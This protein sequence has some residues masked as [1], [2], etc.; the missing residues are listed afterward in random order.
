[1]DM[2]YGTCT[3]KIEVAPDAKIIRDDICDLED[4]TVGYAVCKYVR[5]NAILCKGLVLESYNLRLCN[6]KKSRPQKHKI[7]VLA[8][9]M[10]LPGEK[11]KVYLTVNRK[12]VIVNQIRI[13]N[14]KLL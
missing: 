10:S 1:M 9:K 2:K 12:G 14:S 13:E 11:I 8:H 3:C 6:G 4:A 5:K 7:I